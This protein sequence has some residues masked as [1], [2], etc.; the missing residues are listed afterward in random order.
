MG[1]GVSGVGSVLK[2]PGFAQ[3]SHNPIRRK[4]GGVHGFIWPGESDQ[5]PKKLATTSF[6]NDKNCAVLLTICFDR[7]HVSK[8]VFV[9]VLI[10]LE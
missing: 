10:S 5:L 9:I 3:H 6:G 4:G 2:N 7:N 8:T 1:I